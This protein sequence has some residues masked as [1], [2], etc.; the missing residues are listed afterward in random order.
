M[1]R[2]RAQGR[3]DPTHHEG[4]Q[5]I[6]G[7]IQGGLLRSETRR[8]ALRALGSEIGHLCRTRNAH[9]RYVGGQNRSRSHANYAPSCGAIFAHIRLLGL[10]CAFGGDAES[11]NSHHGDCA[12]PSDV[13]TG[14]R[15]R[16][17]WIASS[18]ASSY[19][20]RS[21]GIVAAISSPRCCCDI[22]SRAN[23]RR[24]RL[25][26]AASRHPDFLGHRRN[27]VS[28]PHIRSTWFIAMSGRSCS[29]SSTY[30]QRLFVLRRPV[31]TWTC[32]T[33]C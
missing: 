15:R 7:A 5:A 12:L 33:R 19:W 27:L 10:R 22:S 17:R 26:A 21:R 3:C 28:G 24:L 32:S 18:M 4:A 25:R 29:A 6:A 8:V 14:R 31:Q 30:S 9:A 1:G 2:E 16:N 13:T 23:S 20:R 11:G